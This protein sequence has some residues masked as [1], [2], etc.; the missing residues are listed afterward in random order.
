MVS[1][2]PFLPGEALDFRITGP[3]TPPFSVTAEAVHTSPMAHAP[4]LHR[5]GFKFV[6]GRVIQTV[7]VALIDQ[8]MAAVGYHEPVG[9]VFQDVGA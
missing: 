4:G 6:P 3:G 9:S 1:H 2:L 8:L 7:P 5:T